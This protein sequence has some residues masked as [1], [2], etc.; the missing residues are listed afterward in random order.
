MICQGTRRGAALRGG[1]GR[2]GTVLLLLPLAALLLFSFFVPILTFLA[3]SFVRG[4]EAAE[5]YG[6]VLQDPTFLRVGLRTLEIALVTTVLSFILGFPV[7]MLIARAKGWVAA[8]AT[9]CVVIPLWTSVLVRS[10]A[11]VIL[12]QRNGI[13]NNALRDLGLISQPLSLI[14]T[15][16]AVVLAMTQ[17]LLPFMILPIAA[18]L[19]QI[20]PELSRAALSLGAGRTRAFLAVTAPL[21][22]PGVAAGC[23]MTFVLALG[24]YVTPALVGGPRQLMLA[25]L[26]S[27]Q[28]TEL[29][30]WPLA[31]A[32]ATV[33]LVFSLGITLG[34]RRLL[35]ADK[36]MA[37]G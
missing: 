36:A 22:L 31:A 2:A 21:S 34:F 27:Q 5:P 1:I 14:Y 29:L 26:I 30:D 28:A 10:Y 18:T 17:V 35:G 25:T 9:A 32:L 15:E 11:W 19:R 33:L 23:I 16:G 8:L 3:Q 20:P 12:L 4:D 24:F 13:I 37:H 6:R 7:A